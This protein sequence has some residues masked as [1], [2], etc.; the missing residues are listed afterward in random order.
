MADGSGGDADTVTIVCQSVPSPRSTSI[1]AIAMRQILQ[2]FSERYPHIRIEPFFMPG[3]EG[4]GMDSGPLMAIA[5]GT[6]PDA[7][8]VNFRQSST[9][10]QRGFLEPMEVML[11]RLQSRNPQTRQ[12]DQGGNWLADPSVDEIANALEKIKA[13]VPGPAW[14]VVYRTGPGHDQPHV[15][16]LPYNNLVM[17]LLYRKDLFAQAGLNPDRPPNDW[18]ELLDYARRLTV[19]Q[20]RQ[21][22]LGLG[23]ILSFS[24]YTFLVSNGGRAVEQDADSG[25]WQAVYDSRAA[26]EAYAFVWELAEGSFERDGEVIKGAAYVSGGDL[27]LKWNRGEI[28]MQFSYL[29]QDMLATINPQQVGIAPVPLAPNG[30]RGSEINATMLGIFAGST[31]QQQLATMQFIWFLTSAEADE[32]QTRVYVQNGYGSFVNPN[33]LEK[34]GYDRLL[35]RVPAGWKQA[36]ETAMANGVPEPYGR[37]TQNIWRY[38]TR[39]ISQALELDLQDVPYEQ[40][41]EQ[42]HGLLEDSVRAFN[43][44][45]LGNLTPEEIRYRRIVA[46]VVLLGVGLAFVIGFYNVWR[47]FGNVSRQ[48]MGPNAKIRFSWGYVLV[49]PGMLL[50]LGW[51]YV[52]LIGGAAM[53]VTDYQ[54]VLNST[55]VGLDNFAAALF[56]ENFWLGFL[57]TFYFVTLIIV[58]GFWPPILLAILLDE[59][60]TSFLKYLYRTIFYLPAIISGII[61]MFLWKQLFDPSSYGPLNQLL[62]ALNTL[63]PVPATFVKLTL[64]ALWCSF[65]YVAI[66]LP[67]KLDELGWGMRIGMWVGAAVVL[68]GPMSLVIFGDGSFGQRLSHLLFGRFQLEALEYLRDPGTAMICCVLPSVWAT[69]GPGCLLYLAAL[70]TVPEDLYEAA[71]IDG[72]SH[73]HKIFYITLPQLKFLI[74]IQF[75]A[76]VV[77]AFKGSANFILAM[78]GGGPNE[79]TM[80]LALEIFMRAFLELDFG[81]AAAMAWM[82][83]AVLI[84]FTAYQMRMLARAEFKGGR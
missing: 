7:I 12:T 61:V 37:N 62:L 56:D 54:L 76:A 27:A 73:W 13:R 11:A 3:I 23:D 42:I 69:A 67:W 49:L 17:V 74:V 36:F 41:V 29:R 57:R 14:P 77:G 59:V 68:F 48:Q 5:T 50:V 10:I 52:P 40:R 6:P 2:R 75:I 30:Q 79:S 4:T 33:M 24:T 38:M 43:V 28:A 18:D 1:D 64:V 8:Y 35:K 51:A 66:K 39:P 81:I 55:F 78:T 53:A 58:L 20:R 22:G 45:V 47:Y 70:K 60:P 16:A 31:P 19:P 26:A 25:Q 9:Y 80:V 72:A 65:V 46:A 82:L 63:G 15:W 44:K 83:G 34:F 32:I 21:Y 84:G 71:D